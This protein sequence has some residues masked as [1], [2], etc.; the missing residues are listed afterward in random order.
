[1]LEKGKNVKSTF[2]NR[3]DDVVVDV[4]VTCIR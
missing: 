3:K 2:Q 1:M 4:V